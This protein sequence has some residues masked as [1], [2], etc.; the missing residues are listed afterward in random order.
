MAAQ[1]FGLLGVNGAGKSTTFGMLT[2][3]HTASSGDAFI[4]GHSITRELQVLL[5]CDINVTRVGP[6]VAR[7]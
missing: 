7:A 1:V 6:R 2:G 3:E 4:A 5:G